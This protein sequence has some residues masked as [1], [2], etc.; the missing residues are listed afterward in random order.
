[1]DSVLL[2]FGARCAPLNLLAVVRRNFYCCL[3]QHNNFKEGKMHGFHVYHI[4]QFV[5]LNLMNEKYDFLP[6]SSR[7][8][9][10]VFPA[11]KRTVQSGLWHAIYLETQ[12]NSSTKIL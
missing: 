7:F 6:L 9:P 11:V 3:M 1:M 2:R 12:M 5:W 10:D 4:C 8:Y